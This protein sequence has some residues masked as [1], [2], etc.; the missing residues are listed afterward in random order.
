MTGIYRTLL[1][2]FEMVPFPGP[3]WT[4][5]AYNYLYI[6]VRETQWRIN[7]LQKVNL[8]DVSFISITFLGLV[9][10]ALGESICFSEMGKKLSYTQMLHVWYIYLHL[11]PNVV[12]YT[13]PMEHI[14]DLEPPHSESETPQSYRNTFQSHAQVLWNRCNPL[15]HTWI[16][17]GVAGKTCHFCLT[18]YDGIKSWA[19]F[20]DFIR[21]IFFCKMGPKS[22]VLSRGP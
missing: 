5:K 8:P 15:R 16:P 19:F 12:R 1:F 20:S 21:L 13:T 17:G 10:H 14:W 22:P 4:W 6:P 11:A 18:T 9:W 7:R 2:F 3:C